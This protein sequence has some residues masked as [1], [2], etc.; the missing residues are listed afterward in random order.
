MHSIGFL[1]VF[2]LGFTHWMS[3]IS[4]AALKLRRWALCTE[5]QCHEKKASLTDLKTTIGRACCPH[6]WWDTNGEVAIT[7][8]HGLHGYKASLDS[9]LPLIMQ[10]RHT[11]LISDDPSDYLSS[12]SKTSIK[13]ASPS[14]Q[15]LEK[16][17]QI[18]RLL[19]R[20]TDHL[21]IQE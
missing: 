16:S 17:S 15:T 12:S 8:Q 13:P 18:V 11:D 3:L 14:S 2:P 20:L 6:D 9:F 4:F 7:N 5:A 1:S 21:S 19:M 10:W